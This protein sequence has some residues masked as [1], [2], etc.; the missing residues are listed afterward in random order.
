M[1]IGGTRIA[2]GILKYFQWGGAA[3][4]KPCES[5]TLDITASTSLCSIEVLTGVVVQGDNERRRVLGDYC[6]PEYRLNT[7]SIRGCF[8]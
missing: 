2:K 7:C 5:E 4:G 1:T 3:L 6:I 8:Q